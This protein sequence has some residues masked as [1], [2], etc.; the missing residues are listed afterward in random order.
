MKTLNFKLVSISEAAH[1]YGVSVQTMRRWD[2]LGKLKSN[3]R[4]LGNHRRYQLQQKS[5][6]SVGYAQVSSSDQK[7]GYCQVSEFG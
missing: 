4:T 2:S 1:F 6:L 3:A 5:K 7:K